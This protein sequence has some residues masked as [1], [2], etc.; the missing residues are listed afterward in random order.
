MTWDNSRLR[1]GLRESEGLMKRTAAGIGRIAA[2]GAGGV[3]GFLGVQRLFDEFDRIGKLSTQFDL[4]V[5]FMQRLNLAASLS[6]ANIETVAKSMKRMI[7]NATEAARGVESYE[8]AFESLGLDAA[9]YIKLSPDEQFLALADAVAKAEDPMKAHAALLRLGGS[10]MSE[11]I[12]LLKEG[13]SGIAKLTDN[14]K[15]LNEEGVKRIEATNDAWEKLVH[16]VKTGA[17]KILAGDF[18]PNRRE[19]GILGFM[20]RTGESVASGLAFGAALLPG[21]TTPGEAFRAINQTARESENAGWMQQEREKERRHRE[22]FFRAHGF[23]PRR[24]QPE[25]ETRPAPAMRTL[26]VRPSTEFSRLDAMIALQDDRD[27]AGFQMRQDP[28]FFRRADPVFGIG[29]RHERNLGLVGI[30]HRQAYADRLGYEYQMQAMGSTSDA[31]SYTIRRSQES[32]QKKM[33][34]ALKE[35]AENTKSTSETLEDL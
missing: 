29:A 20:Q 17:A 27:T 24:G 28:G 14:M 5:E 30:Q 19:S 8:T 32:E 11:L 16:N 1:R 9:N 15:I 31:K 22:A 2:V 3:G 18:N 6:G 10:R 13:A 21:G 33:L 25:S 12:P 35:I 26:R 34:A 23:Y 7:L 4:P